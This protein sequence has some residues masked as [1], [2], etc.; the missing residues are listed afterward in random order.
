VE[1]RVVGGLMVGSVGTRY[2][3]GRQ[4]PATALGQVLRDG[5]DGTHAWPD[6][7]PDFF[8]DVSV[9][10]PTIARSITRPGRS[11]AAIAAVDIS[12]KAVARNH[13]SAT[14]DSPVSGGHGS[15]RGG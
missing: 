15:L 5:P 4:Q 8:G 7:R 3:T 1:A 11:G 2:F 14:S 9:P 12:S 6:P 13:P 10:E